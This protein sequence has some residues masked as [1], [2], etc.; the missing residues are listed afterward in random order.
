MHINYM[1]LSKNTNSSQ[2]CGSFEES[3]K[4]RNL[5]RYIESYRRLEAYISS[6]VN[7]SGISNM[8]NDTV[9]R[10]IESFTIESYCVGA[11]TAFEELRDSCG[12]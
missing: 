1:P 3:R 12:H 7:F 5:S 11:D 8:F 2:L 6:C 10:V 9:G 4:A